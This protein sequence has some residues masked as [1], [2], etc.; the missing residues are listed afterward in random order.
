MIQNPLNFSLL[1]HETCQNQTSLR[2]GAYIENALYVMS[3]YSDD[4]VRFKSIYATVNGL[5][6]DISTSSTSECP[7]VPSIIP[8]GQKEEHTTKWMVMDNRNP[9][10]PQYMLEWSAGE[11]MGYLDCKLMGS[12]QQYVTVDNDNI[13]LTQS[14]DM[15]STIRILR[16]NMDYATPSN[17]LLGIVQC[18][19]LYLNHVS[20][21]PSL[22]E[23]PISAIWTFYMD[24]TY[25]LGF[26]ELS[27]QIQSHV[28]SDPTY[29]PSWYL[30][31]DL[32]SGFVMTQNSNP[33]TTTWT[34]EIT[35]RM[36]QTDG[37]K[38]YGYLKHNGYY[39]C[40]STGDENDKNTFTTSLA[41]PSSTECFAMTLFNHVFL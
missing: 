5:E 2:F 13:N 1:L 31:W 28:K 36:F 26:Q 6:G 41:K 29:F 3:I 14:L 39:V 37:M 10:Q 40:R 17:A 9:V 21:V 35:S 25:Q 7:H 30:Q 11:Q 15:V 27:F 16:P 20:K 18:N 32:N 4:N 22:S 12:E 33:M 23:V 34:L 19:N 24:S 38:I 8:N